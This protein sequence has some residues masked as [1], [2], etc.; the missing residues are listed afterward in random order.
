MYTLLTHLLISI[1]FN[2][3]WLHYRWLWFSDSYTATGA[4]NRHNETRGTCRWSETMVENKRVAGSGVHTHT[5]THTHIYC[6]FMLLCW[7][8]TTYYMTNLI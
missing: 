1:G 4:R 3:Y 6:I 7:W 5:H 8:I 2:V